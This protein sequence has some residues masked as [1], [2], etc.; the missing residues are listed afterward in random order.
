MFYLLLV[1]CW[2]MT[3]GQS[4]EPIM[5]LNGTTLFPVDSVCKSSTGK[6]YIL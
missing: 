5:C 4:E 1:L 2:L 6:I 3:E